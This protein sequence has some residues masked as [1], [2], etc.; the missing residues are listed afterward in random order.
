[1]AAGASTDAGPNQQ[2][3]DASGLPTALAIDCGG[4]A[5][6][7]GLKLPC[8]VYPNP[9]LN[10]TACFAL[11][12]T[13]RHPLPV[14]MFWVPLEYLA[15]HRNEPIN[16]NQIPQPLWSALS[17]VV[18]GGVEYR[19]SHI[20]TITASQVDVGA[21]SYAGRFESVEFTGN[22]DGGDAIVCSATA[23]PFWAV[24]GFF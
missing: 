5:S 17:A 8:L 1:M 19:L 22:G 23:A 11:D 9:P 4:S 2:G 16:L 14:L 20:G 18:S 21:K 24:P 10:A 15:A 13:S 3:F 12:D 7:I 6:P